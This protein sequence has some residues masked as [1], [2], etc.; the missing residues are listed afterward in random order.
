MNENEVPTSGI[1]DNATESNSAGG[2]KHSHIRMWLFCSMLVLALVGMGLTMST[3]KGGWEFWV[4]LLTFYGCV[5]VFWAWQRARRTGDPVWRMVRK[6]VYHWSS[7]LLIF[8]I[9]V[10]FER[11]EI[12]SRE[13]A[14]DVALL[15]L[16][17]ACLLAGVHFEWTFLL[18]GIILTV[19]AISVGY[20]EQ[21]VVWLIMLPSIA[22]AVWVYF[23]VHKRRAGKRGQSKSTATTA[24]SH[25]AT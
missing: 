17:M 18:I 12:I 8:A 4:G 14:S 11:T 24:R 16:A 9:L 21:Y 10:V 2:G 25:D 22:A 3:E 15:V 6:Q 5:S 20:L 19:M 7:V 23:Q 1:D 13:A